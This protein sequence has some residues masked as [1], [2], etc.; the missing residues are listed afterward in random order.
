LFGRV[1]LESLTLPDLPGRFDQLGDRG[2]GRSTDEPPLNC[3][4]KAG[5]ED[6]TRTRYLNRAAYFS[7][8]VSLLAPH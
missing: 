5:A 2:G 8:S 6:R 4:V 7:T 3:V 1:A